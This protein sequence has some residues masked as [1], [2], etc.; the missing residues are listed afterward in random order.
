M[1]DARPPAPTA[2]AAAA[3][4]AFAAAILSGIGTGGA[5]VGGGG[6]DGFFCNIPGNRPEATDVSIVGIEDAIA[7]APVAIA[8][9]SGPSSFGND[10]KTDII[11][12]FGQTREY[13]MLSPSAAFC[14]FQR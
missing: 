6:A 10:L 3:C 5:T 8:A 4:C 9:T 11:D 13:V 2:L 12:S 7:L 14:A 1:V